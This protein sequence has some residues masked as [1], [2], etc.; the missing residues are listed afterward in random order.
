MEKPEKIVRDNE[1]IK[2][3]VLY[4]T[5]PPFFDASE[6]DIIHTNDSKASDSLLAT[7]DN[8]G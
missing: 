8:W 2:N 7:Q 1:K 6:S 4:L 3:Q 5:C